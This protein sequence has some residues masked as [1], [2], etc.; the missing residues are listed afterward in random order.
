[1]VPDATYTAANSAINAML[2]WWGCETGPNTSGCDSIVNAGASSTVYTPWLE[3]ALHN[4]PRVVSVLNA[5]VYRE[6]CTAARA[7]GAYRRMR[8]R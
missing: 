7:G 2:N 4:F 8:V 5:T 1:M 3:H 6:A